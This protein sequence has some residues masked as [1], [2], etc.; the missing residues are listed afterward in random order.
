MAQFQNINTMKGLM[1]KCFN[2]IGVKVNVVILNVDTHD[3]SVAIDD[4]LRVI[5]APARMDRELR[6][7]VF[8]DKRL[9]E[10]DKDI[11]HIVA[12]VVRMRTTDIVSE[13]ISFLN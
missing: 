11:S 4:Y 6:Y 2:K 10:E 9:M 5:N 8:R 13:S 7:H 12:A 1:D 3:E